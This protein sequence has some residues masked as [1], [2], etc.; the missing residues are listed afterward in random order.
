[1]QGVDEE[2]SMFG[3]ADGLCDTAASPRRG[4]NCGAGAHTT[5]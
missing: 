1:M 2:I 4:S 5:F 3:G